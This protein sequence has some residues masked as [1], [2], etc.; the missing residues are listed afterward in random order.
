MVQK[1]SLPGSSRSVRIVT[2]LLG[3]RSSAMGAVVQAIS[4][5]LH[6]S[7]GA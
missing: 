6:Q 5:T 1:R 3:R 2:A 4:H 7:L